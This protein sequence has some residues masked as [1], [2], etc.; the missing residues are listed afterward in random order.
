[1]ASYAKELNTAEIAYAAIDE[2]DKVEFIIHIKE[3]PSKEARNAEMALFC[4]NPQDAEGILLQGGLI[5]RAIMMNIELY[6]WDR[7]LE[8]AV[9]HKTHV[10]TVLAYRQKFLDDFDKKETNK[11]FLQYAEGVEVDWEKI[12]T[13]IALEYQKERDKPVKSQRK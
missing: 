11:R 5:F 12:E 4:G 3:I 8:L 13:K 2:A 7:A 10:D 6:N 1:M 9:K